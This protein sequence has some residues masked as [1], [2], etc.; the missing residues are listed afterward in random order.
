[1]P[2]SHAETDLL[3]RRHSLRKLQRYI[4]LMAIIALV[5]IGLIFGRV[6][7]YGLAWLDG[8][9]GQGL[10]PGIFDRPI[11]VISGHA[12]FDS[13]AVCTDEAGAMTLSEADI[14]AEIARRVVRRLRRAGADVLLLEEFDPRLE[15]LS[16]DALI[17]L[18][19]D[20]CIQASGFKAAHHISTP[21]PEVEAAFLACVNRYYGDITG[22]PRHPNTITHDMTQYHA[23]RRIDPATPAIILEMGFLGGDQA[24]LTGQPELVA[25]GVTDSILCF[26]DPGYLETR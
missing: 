13:G 26:L 10:V 7:G 6:A 9:P 16:A 2:L 25:K 4:L 20:S 1:M 3:M 14:N 5:G 11:A 17:S 24:L 23:F 15:G 12:G 19:A 21:I 22:L 8:V 18:H